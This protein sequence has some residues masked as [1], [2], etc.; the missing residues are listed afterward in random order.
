[1]SARCR[2]YPLLPLLLSSHTLLPIL[3]TSLTLTLVSSQECQIV[4]D[5]PEKVSYEFKPRRIQ[6]DLKLTCKGTVEPK[7]TITKVEWMLHNKRISS[8]D[9]RYKISAVE[10]AK[11][12]IVNANKRYIG[13]YHATIT[14]RAPDNNLETVSCQVNVTGDPIVL[15]HNDYSTDE[16]S[17]HF[18]EGKQKLL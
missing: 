10:D 12:T 18:R 3:L 8:S 17:R 13:V 4:I 16:L 14:A 1:M 5:P 2:P 6:E 9:S 15:F 7:C 11:L